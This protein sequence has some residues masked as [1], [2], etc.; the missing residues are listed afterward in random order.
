VT[1]L[2]EDRGTRQNCRS[3]LACA[4]RIGHYACG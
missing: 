2:S 3:A 1:S 4:H